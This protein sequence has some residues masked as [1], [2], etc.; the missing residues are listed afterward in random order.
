MSTAIRTPRT[1]PDHKVIGNYVKGIGSVAPDYKS[2]IYWCDSYD[3]SQG[4]WLTS[5]SVYGRRINVSERAIDRN[6]H[7]VYHNNPDKADSLY[8]T[9][10]KLQPEEIKL[11]QDHIQYQT[12]TIPWLLRI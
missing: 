2:E 7:M 6:F 4:Y 10:G 12:G 8:C 9:W 1:D 5:L 11:V 3:P